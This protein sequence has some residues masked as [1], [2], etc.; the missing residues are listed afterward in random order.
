MEKFKSP[1]LAVDYDSSRLSY[2]RSASPKLD[3]WRGVIHQGKVTTRSGK[4]FRNKWTQSLFGMA[5]LEGLDGEFCV[6][7][8][9][10]P[11]VFNLTD[12]AMKKFEGEPDVRFYVFDIYDAPEGMDYTDRLKE[13]AE[14]V[15]NFNDWARSNELLSGRVI[16]LPQ[17]MIYSE[18]Q[19]ELYET[20]TLVDGFEGVMLRDV[21]SP[22]KYGRSTL[23]QGYLLKVKRWTHDE[24]RIVGFE[25][26]M[27]NDNEAFLDELGRTKRSSHKE[28]LRPSGMLGA[29]I[30]EN[31]E[32]WPGQTFNVSCGS[33]KHDEKREA[34]AKARAGEFDGEWLRLKHLPHGAKDAPRHGLFAGFRADEDR[35]SLD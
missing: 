14:R 31:P 13:A 4:P 12:A 25:E 17:T 18:D 27:H 5:A 22:Y 26:M 24:A 8:Y 35:L 1:M 29:F 20:A 11:N 30:C 7:P 33:M 2:P 6:G 19:L 21:G 15:K 28:N 3:G 34:L 10:A 23:S 32:R 16:L 9:N